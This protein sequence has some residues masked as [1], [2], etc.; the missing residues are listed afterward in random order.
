M[1]AAFCLTK[2][3]SCN[4]AVLIRNAVFFRVFI[5]EKCFKMFKE[6]SVQIPTQR[7]QIL[8]FLPDGQVMLSDAHQSQEAEQFKVASVQTSWQHVHMYFKVR[9]DS[10]FPS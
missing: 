6:D 4:V 5:T 3:L 7:S 1:F 8:K 10:S 2:S 9:E